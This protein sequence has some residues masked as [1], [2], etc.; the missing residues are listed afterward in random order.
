MKKIALFLIVLASLVVV[1]GCNNNKKTVFRPTE[2]DSATNT[3]SV[4]TPKSSETIV[5]V[6]DAE[7][8]AAKP[9]PIELKTDKSVA[10]TDEAAK[11]VI[12]FEVTSLSKNIAQSAKG[13]QLIEGTTPA[14]T[15]KVLVNDFP[16]SKYKAGETKWSYIAAVSLGNL[17]TGDNN[18]T[19]KAVDANDTELGSKTFTITYKG[20]ETAKLAS[21]GP[22]NM[23]LAGLITFMVMGLLSLRRRN[24]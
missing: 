7:P 12:P 21:T 4:E 15:A 24:A 22:D 2:G 6:K 5:K 17:K 16:L 8:V 13:Y 1:V 19:V 18:F 9:T 14:N 20:L 23:M 10:V 11:P 3:D